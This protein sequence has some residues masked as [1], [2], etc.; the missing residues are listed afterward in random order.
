MYKRQEHTIARV[1]TLIGLVASCFY[2]SWRACFTLAGTDL[3][4]SIPVLLVEISGFVG[5]ALLV[6]ALWP[7]RDRQASPADSID[8]SAV[9]VLVRVHHQGEHE[10]RATLMALRAVAQVSDVIVVDVSAR[11]A[12]ASIAAEF[13][14][15]YAATD[16]GDCSGLAVAVAAARTS[17]FLLLDAGDVPTTDIVSRLARASVDERVAV[18]QGLGVSFAA[19]SI[20][21]GPHGRHDLTFER[22]ALNPALGTRGCAVWTGSGS[23]ISVDALR[24]A[25]TFLVAWPGSATSLEGHYLVCCCRRDGVSPL[26][27]TWRFCRIGS[28][29]PR[30]LCMQIGAPARELAVG[31]S[32]AARVRIPRNNGWR[33]WLGACGRFPAY[34]A[35][36][37]SACSW[38]RSIRDQHRLLRRCG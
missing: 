9:D 15:S 7:Q 14:H 22:G 20:E 37:S 23:L 6:W 10:L 29:T 25:L 21:H 5:G 2:L 36:R 27:P 32:L 12:I 18:V 30:Q 3:W 19:D 8:A 34:A 17:R 26:L 1:V 28:S 38:A 4:L 11:P 24:E 35:L 16:S 13:Q 33:S 31:S